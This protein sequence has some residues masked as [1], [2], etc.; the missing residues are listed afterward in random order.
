MIIILGIGNILN[1]VPFAVVDFDHCFEREKNYQN[2]F[3]PSLTSNYF[4]MIIFTIQKVTVT[5]KSTF[6]HILNK[7]EII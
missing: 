5:L 7:L 4:D 1:K 6:I 3:C 2:T